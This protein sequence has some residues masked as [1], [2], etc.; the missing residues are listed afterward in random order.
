MVK[1]RSMVM[2]LLLSALVILG[3]A[4]SG[5]ESPSQLAGAKEE[6]SPA[7]MEQKGQDSATAMKENQPAGEQ[8][9]TA[10]QNPAEEKTGTVQLT[11][12]VEKGDNGIVIV[13]DQ[14]KYN[15]TGQD[16]SEMVGKTVNVT[17]AVQESA[18]QYTIDVVSFEE[19]K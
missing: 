2:I 1:S 16:L 12:M 18:G 10:Q 4:C 9:Q 7:A 19:S 8:A 3:V 6:R 17:G 13:T 15:V 11:G 5:N 14:G